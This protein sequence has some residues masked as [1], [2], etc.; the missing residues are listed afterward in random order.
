M[1]RRNQEGVPGREVVVPVVEGVGA[2]VS[3]VHLIL[4]LLV[5]ALQRGVR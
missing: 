1:S 5:N 3:P 2:V 4:P